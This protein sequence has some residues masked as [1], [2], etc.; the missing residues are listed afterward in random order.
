MNGENIIDDDT[1]EADDKNTQRHANKLS[2]NI[3][4]DLIPIRARL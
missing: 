4:V 2:K 3:Q 1:V